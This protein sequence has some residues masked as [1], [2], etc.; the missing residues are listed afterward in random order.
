VEKE[1][2]GNKRRKKESM[3]ETECVGYIA[4]NWIPVE[5]KIGKKKYCSLRW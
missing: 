2:C 5:R 1:E 3:K 4:K